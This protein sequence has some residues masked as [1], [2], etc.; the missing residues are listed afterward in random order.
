MNIKVILA[1]DHNIMRAGLKSLLESSKKVLIVAEA[2]NGRETVS[3]ARKFKPDIVVMDVAMPDMNG[4]EATRKL[5]RLAPDV[6]VLAL[7]GHS[8]GMFVKGMLEAGA[9]G[10]LLKDAATT[11]LLTAII[12]ISKG[13]IYVSPSVANT[14]VGDYLQRVKGEIGPDLKILSAREREVLQLVSEGKSS[15]QIATT[16]HLSDRTIETH[17]RRIMN[18]LGMRS[19]A[20][21]TKY[22]IREGLTTLDF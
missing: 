18:K 9:K 12:T 3:L 22:A 7:S 15:S 10:Y 1:D 14:L 13:R 11:E 2:N 20:E 8:D 5:A 21:L 4:V 17:R 19:I 6:R 16:L